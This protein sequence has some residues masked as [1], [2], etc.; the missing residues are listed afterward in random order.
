MMVILISCFII[1]VISNRKQNTFHYHRDLKYKY[2]DIYFSWV[3]WNTRR[4]WWLQSPQ[5]PSTWSSSSHWTRSDM[6]LSCWWHE[7]YM[8]IN[9][10]CNVRIIVIAQSLVDLRVHCHLVGQLGD[11]SDSVWLRAKLHVQD[12]CLSG[13]HL[14]FYH[15]HVPT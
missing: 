7:R 4:A 11:A 15:H 12:V 3:S 1:I 2:K 8:D 5:P 9:C 13:W 14:R 10:L 6:I